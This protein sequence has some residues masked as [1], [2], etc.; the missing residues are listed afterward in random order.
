MGGE[1][2]PP[3]F[4]LLSYFQTPKSSPG[5]FSPLFAAPCQSARY[6]SV[7]LP[8]FFFFCWTFNLMARDYL[9]KLVSEPGQ[10]MITISISTD[11]D[12]TEG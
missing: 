6:Y 10:G 9:K 1:R 4:H 3:V 12:I 7:R 8:K 5:L 2:R 11:C